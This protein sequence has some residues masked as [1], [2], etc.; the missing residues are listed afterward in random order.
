MY[1]LIEMTSNVLENQMTLMYFK[2]LFFKV[3]FKRDSKMWTENVKCLQIVV[4][5]MGEEEE[6][7]IWEDLWRNGS[8]VERVELFGRF[9]QLQ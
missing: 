4:E 2:I 3:M 8:G 9:R 1:G 7:E 6:V 5:F